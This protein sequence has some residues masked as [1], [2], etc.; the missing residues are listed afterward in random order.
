[1]DLF[2]FSSF[3]EA[4]F[5]YFVW[6][7]SGTFATATTVS[8]MSCSL[9]SMHSRGSYGSGV[10]LHFTDLTEAFVHIMYNRSHGRSQEFKVFFRK[11]CLHIHF[12]VCYLWS[13]LNCTKLYERFCPN[14]VWLMVR[15]DRGATVLGLTSV[16]WRHKTL[17]LVFTIVGTSRS[18]SNRA[19]IAFRRSWQ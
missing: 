17:P 4:V 9:R 6:R 18:S 3:S 11:K 7:D 1:M 15:P 14:T 16:Y 19:A 10:N 12:H 5:L 8:I 13:F 2:I